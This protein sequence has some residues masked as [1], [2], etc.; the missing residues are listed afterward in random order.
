M[1]KVIL[2]ILLVLTVTLQAKF[3]KFT[4]TDTDGIQI[5]ITESKD[6]LIF[7]QYKGKAIFLVIFGHNCPPCKKEIPEFVKLTEKY[8]D[9]LLIIAIEAQ[10]Y[11]VEQLQAFKIENGIIEY[12]KMISAK[13]NKEEK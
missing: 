5:N 6:G 9:K 4:L 1:K 2:T 8:R 3:E 12:D 10:R 13:I 11:S 7:E